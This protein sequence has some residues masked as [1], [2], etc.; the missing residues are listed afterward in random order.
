MALRWYIYIHMYIYIYIPVCIV[1]ISILIH[2]YVIVQICLC[3]I[4]PVQHQPP[5]T[6]QHFLQGLTCQKRKVLQ[7]KGPWKWWHSLALKT[8]SNSVQAWLQSSWRLVQTCHFRSG[9]L[10][11]RLVTIPITHGGRSRSNKI[12]K[13]LVNFNPTWKNR[14]QVDA[15]AGDV[16]LAMVGA[17]PRQVWKSCEFRMTWHTWGMHWKFPSKNPNRCITVAP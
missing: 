6:M 15:S 5:R 13:P 11:N 16:L 9:I 7:K 10:M 2:I 3:R 17:H 12:V 1:L 4:L 8:V 14:L